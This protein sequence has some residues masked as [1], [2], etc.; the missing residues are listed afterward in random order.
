MTC[1]KDLVHEQ[2]YWL[3][4]TMGFYPVDSGKVLESF[5]QRNEMIGNALNDCWVRFEEM[6][7]GD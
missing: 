4:K 7:R 3:W 6:I 2:L 5:K 1:K